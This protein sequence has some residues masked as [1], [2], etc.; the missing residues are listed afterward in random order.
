MRFILTLFLVF[1]LSFPALAELP[2]VESPGASN[3][4]LAG[5]VNPAAWAVQ[6][7]GGSLFS[8]CKPQGS[9]NWNLSGVLSS[10]NLVFGYQNHWLDGESLTDY[11]LGFSFG[12]RDLAFGF[13]QTWM[14]D[15]SESQNNLG[16]IKRDRLYSIG[17]S[18]NWTGDFENPVYQADLGI[19]PFGPRLTLFAEA[20]STEDPDSLT[21][22]FGAEAFVFPGVA[23]AAKRWDD[24]KIS[25][26]LK[27]TSEKGRLGAVQFM[28]ED[29]ESTHTAYVMESGRRGSHYRV[30][31]KGSAYPELHL[32]GGFA[33]RRYEFF[34]KGRTFF[35]TLRQINRYA[36]NPNVKGLV[37][38]ASG[39]GTSPEQILELRDQLAG[40]R[41]EGK[42]VIVYVD[43]ASLFGYM[44]ASVADQI[45]I[46]PEGGLDLR[47]LAF[48]STYMKETLDKAGVGI[49]EF[50]YFRYKSALEILARY[51]PSEGQ[52]EQSDALLED[53][54]ETAVG[55]S[56]EARGV[57][58]ETWDR[59]VEELGDLSPKEA[60]A[61]GL[62]D[63]IGDFHDMKESAKDIGRR[64]TLDSSYTQLAG[65]S[66]DPAWRGEN[67]GEPD[68]IALLYAIG[69]CS[70]DTGIQGRRLSKAIRKARENK[71][72]KAV[73]LRADS[74]G[75][76]PLPSDLVARELK[77]TMEEKPV[78]ISQGQV[79]ASGGYWISMHSDRILAS[80]LTV[81]GSIGVIGG[82]FYNKTLGDKLGM[83]PYTLK[84]GSH[85]DLY[86]GISLPLLGTLPSRPFDERELERVE[87]TIKDLYQG[88]LEQVAEGRDM[89]VEEVAEVA[90]G[91]VWSGLR[92]LDNG[93]VDELGGLWDALRLAKELAGIDPDETVA[94]S[95]GPSLGQFNFGSLTPSLLGLSSEEMARLR[96]P[97]RNVFSERELEYLETLRA[98]DGKPVTTMAPAVLLDGSSESHVF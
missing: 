64:E 68:R 38:N 54:Y 94:I 53:L 35:G 43:R 84:R 36:E 44:F 91:R 37:I 27:L 65:L 62:V 86:S 55:L 72:V 34:D 16:V 11:T 32:K 39:F 69:G 41:A 30:P 82:H 31:E 42:K 50:R 20:S 9:E 5:F 33:Y 51:E 46:D 77:L 52:T 28:D 21:H 7:S 12:D 83:K 15:K 58:R 80:P 61:E 87:Y 75:G 93:L 1:L 66:G 40:F 29:G 4:L 74:P 90:Q 10:E 73:V 70:M 48:T 76:D 59:M 79:A 14:G 98:N 47:G 96:N 88:F 24:G 6:G 23:L 56:L 49:Q 22:A 85:S 57:D 18:G 78:I 13:S 92:G 81:T 95:Q 17:L 67:W 2:L 19:R 97:A 89:S 3:S 45:W 8:F 60:L 71:R 26:G 25:L 63:S